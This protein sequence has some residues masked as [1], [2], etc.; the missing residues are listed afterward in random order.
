MTQIF[1]SSRLF[2][3]MSL[4]AAVDAGL[5]GPPGR[6]RIL[7]VSHDA[8][9]PELTP[10]PNER[11]GYRPL[12]SRFDE[13]IS[14]NEVIAPQHP[15]SWNPRPEDLPMLER[16]L[17]QVWGLGADPVELAVE[18]IQSSPAKTLAAIF[19]EATVTVYSDGLATYGATRATPPRGVGSRLSR[20]VHLDLVPGLTPHLLS[21]YGAPGQ[22]LP[23][24]AF[25]KVLDEVC[26]E[27]DPL[28]S[29]Y[30]TLGEH[31]NAALIVGQ[32]FSELGILEPD[33]EDQMHL[34]MLQGVV[35]RGHSTVL[36]KP[37]PHSP[38]RLFELLTDEAKRLGARLVI[39][40][41][42]VPAEA[43]FA[44]A[45]PALVVGICSTAM[46]TARCY[47][48][49]PT[50]TLGVVRLL[51]RLQPFENSNRIPASIIDAI[52]PRLMPDGT[53]QPPMIGPQE[54]ESKLVPLVTSI[55][56]CM[57]PGRRPDLRRTAVEYLSSF[58]P[59]DIPRRYFRPRLYQLGLPGGRAPVE[60]T[61]AWRPSLR[62][63]LGR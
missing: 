5:F 56:Y 4:A 1:V 10:P 6:R 7:L 52:L 53:L 54:V 12:L 37:H 35:A 42:P 11:P 32:Y 23:G 51:R 33:E 39:I 58:D 2:G 50:V 22:E 41:D 20:L 43:W 17:R 57:Q 48:G 40:D 25:L 3:A 19:H 49:I 47:F 18:A 30:G 21:E 61:P 9:I 63:L 46:M 38:P 26:A 62:G 13:V 28:I 24:E 15:L 34:E 60:Q 14:L 59:D 45:R 27:I 55:A 44:R 31:D 29:R 8:E 36:F 16:L